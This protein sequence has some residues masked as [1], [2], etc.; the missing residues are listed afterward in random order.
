MKG[1]QTSESHNC[2]PV[3]LNLPVRSLYQ[4]PPLVSLQCLCP[5]PHLAAQAQRAPVQVAPIAVLRRLRHHPRAA[6]SHLR[7]LQAQRQAVQPVHC[8]LLHPNCFRWS[9]LSTACLRAQ[10]I[11][12]AIQ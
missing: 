6:N 10:E 2:H 12:K 8:G 9:A 11:V 1:I 5:V 7:M 3:T 4:R